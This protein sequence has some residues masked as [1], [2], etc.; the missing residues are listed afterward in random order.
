MSKSTI[1]R[2][3]IGSLMAIGAGVVLV[4]FAGLV[5][6]ANGRLLMNGP[7]VVGVQENG[8]GWTMAAVALVGVVVLIGA[9]IGQ[10][11]AWIGA[12]MNTFLLE[13]KTWFMILLLLGLL[14][15]GVVAMIAY[16]VA[17][18][19]GTDPAAQRTAALK[20]LTT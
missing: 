2:I 5:A 8:L 17:G 9:S 10:L 14:S 13:D 19:D 11:V 1:S 4:T 18:P 12:V 6:F 20:P 15:F 3:F 7:D 16:L